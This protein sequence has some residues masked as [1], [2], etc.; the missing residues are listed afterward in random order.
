MTFECFEQFPVSLELIVG[1]LGPKRILAGTLALSISSLCS[2]SEHTESPSSHVIK[3]DVAQNTVE[4]EQNVGPS[5]RR[6]EERL[7]GH[8]VALWS[9]KEWCWGGQRWA[10]LFPRAHDLSV[11]GR[12]GIRGWRKCGLKLKW[13]ERKKCWDKQRKKMGRIGSQ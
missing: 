9:S 11:P 10:W 3:W 4:K 7:S 2:L 5:T 13:L 1:A 6:G 8:D 12:E